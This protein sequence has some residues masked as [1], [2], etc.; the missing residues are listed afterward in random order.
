M[1]DALK[2]LAAV[3]MIAAT[4]ACANNDFST[5][6]PTAPGADALSG[7]QLSEIAVTF[8]PDA[9]LS[10]CEDNLWQCDMVEL[11]IAQTFEVGTR[12]GAAELLN[13]GKPARMEVRVTE[14]DSLSLL[15]RMTT[16]GVH[17]IGADY[18]LAD[19]ATGR[20]LAKAER[21]DFDR[22]AWGRTAGLIAN[23]TGRTQRVRIAERIADVTRQWLTALRGRGA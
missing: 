23:L 19:A 11:R 15:A 12:A 9:Q 16:G 4:A 7:Y 17:Y 20:E 13:G 6:S 10:W 8:A 21:L 5:V 1:R 2:R 18:R 14:F 22:I 3:S